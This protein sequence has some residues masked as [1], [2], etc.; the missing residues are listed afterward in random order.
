MLLLANRCVIS[1]ITHS[2][3]RGYTKRSH[4]AMLYFRT[5]ARAV[6]LFLTYDLNARRRDRTDSGFR[7]RRKQMVRNPAQTPFIQQVKIYA[8]LSCRNRSDSNDKDNLHLAN[9]GCTHYLKPQATYLHTTSINKY[10]TE[11][12]TNF[13]CITLVKSI[14]H[15]YVAIKRRTLQ[16]CEVVS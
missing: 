16:A 9:K 10:N 4:C 15:V 11:C 1:R 5:T 8:C 3:P 12:L 2:R 14:I 7:H 13:P 6:V